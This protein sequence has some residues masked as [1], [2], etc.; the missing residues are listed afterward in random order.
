M[1][2][3]GKEARSVWVNAKNYSRFSKFCKKSNFRPGDFFDLCMIEA[4][5]GNLKFQNKIK[6]IK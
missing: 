3:N 2:N 4:M 6:K 5:K 1:R